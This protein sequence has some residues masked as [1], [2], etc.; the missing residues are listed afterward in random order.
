M[1]NSHFLQNISNESDS[2][3]I[4]VAVRGYSVCGVVWYRTV[5]VRAET[6]KETRIRSVPVPELA[7]TVS[8]IRLPRNSTESFEQTA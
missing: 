8:M 2:C 1:R 6:Y 7:A 3:C 4:D 5:R